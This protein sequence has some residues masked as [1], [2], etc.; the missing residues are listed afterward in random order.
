MS[1]AGNVM[2]ALDPFSL[3]D[4]IFEPIGWVNQFSMFAV[5]SE[6]LTFRACCYA[7]MTVNIPLDDEFF[8]K[9]KG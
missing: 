8:V 3:F 9:E 4:P 6:K 5:F 1:F 7:H 2:P